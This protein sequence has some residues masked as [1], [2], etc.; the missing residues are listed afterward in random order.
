MY[1]ITSVCCLVPLYLIDKML[2][3]SDF[4]K[5][6]LVFRVYGMLLVA[7]NQCDPCSYNECSVVKHK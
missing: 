1:K 4:I 2:L 5:L 7:Y 6:K 3:W